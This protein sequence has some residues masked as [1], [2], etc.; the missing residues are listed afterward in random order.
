MLRVRSV[1]DVDDFVG[2]PGDADGY[3]D[4]VT[5]MWDGGESKPEWSF[6]LEDDLEMVGRVGYYVSP[7]VTD[8]AWLGTLPPQELFVYGLYLPWKGDYLETGSRLMTESL[9]TIASDVPDLLEVRINNEY[10]SHA[11]A[12]CRLMEALGFDLFHEKQGYWWVDDGTPIEVPDRLTWRSYANVGR[13]AY[14]AAMAPCIA[15]T[16]DRNDRYFWEGCGPD[17]WAQQMTAF[18]A[19]DDEEMWLLGYAG[20]KPVGYVA[21]ATAD[22]WG[23]T[24][25]HIGVHPDHRGNGYINDLMAAG[26]AAAKQRGITTMLSDVDVLNVPMRN[27]MLRANHRDDRRSWHLWVYRREVSA[28]ANRTTKP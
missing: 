11:E 24:I 15:G 9:Q 19:E 5:G 25:A 12:R 16:L 20:N 27:A 2:A 17:N 13:D 10:H 18:V 3:R 4:Q 21:V 26:T 23:S 22:E 6:R 28:I 8:A 1:N 7:T 14:A